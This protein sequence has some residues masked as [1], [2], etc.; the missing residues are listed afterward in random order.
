LSGWPGS[1]DSTQ[2][3]VVY[4]VSFQN[5]PHG[6]RG[7]PVTHPKGGESPQ[8]R[9]LPWRIPPFVPMQHQRYRHY[10]SF[11]ARPTFKPTA[12][13]LAR[14][15]AHRPWRLA[16]AMLGGAGRCAV[17]RARVGKFPAR[18]LKPGVPSVRAQRPKRGF[19]FNDE[20]LAEE[21][22]PCKRGPDIRAW[23]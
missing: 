9:S 19:S 6:L 18:S 5:S 20:R 8:V 10:D 4:R 17:A 7:R 22:V 12:M 21:I 23:K 11:C 3:T 16:S 14:S 1:L 2:A 13:P 15:Q